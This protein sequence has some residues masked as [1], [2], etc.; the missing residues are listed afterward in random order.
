MQYYYYLKGL[1]ELLFRPKVKRHL[2]GAFNG[3]EFRKQIF[4]EIVNEM[5]ITAIIETGS[6]RGTTTRFMRR[7][8]DLPVYTTEVNPR[9]FS[10]TK[11]RF[12]FDGGVSVYHEDSREFL[13]MLGR[14]AA[15]SGGRNFIYLDAHWKDDLPLEKEVQIIC[16]SFPDSVVMVDDFAV[17]GDDGYLYDDYGPGKTL[18]VEYLEN[19]CSEFD[20]E[21]YFPST[22]SGRETG[23]KRGCVVFA[24][25]H[26][27]AGMLGKM[28][29]LRSYK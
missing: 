22:D 16:K 4:S 5:G 26:E 14:D 12:L 7:S 23:S 8:T 13:S 15:L 27:N 9:F 17:P 28:E 10:Y 21:P 11:L 18:N 2:G 29:T 1:F 3:Q 6:F 20:L 25:S 24:A 19:V